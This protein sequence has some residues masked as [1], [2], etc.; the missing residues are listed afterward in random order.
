[1]GAPAASA[2]RRLR[3]CAPDAPPFAD[4]MAAAFRLLAQGGQGVPGD[5]F[6]ALVALL[7]AGLPPQ[8][9][10]QLQRVRG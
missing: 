1:V 4:N 2:F 5:T 6:N 8:L 10:V 9:A 3:L 7:T